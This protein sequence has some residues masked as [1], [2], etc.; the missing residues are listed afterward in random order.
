MSIPND[1]EERPLTF[2]ELRALAEKREKQD[3]PWKKEEE[4]PEV[5][6]EELLALGGKKAGRDIIF[7]TDGET[8]LVFSPSDS[9]LKR[10]ARRTI[11]RWT[12][13]I[14]PIPVSGYD[15]R[16]ELNKSGRE[17]WDKEK[18]EPSLA[19]KAAEQLLACNVEKLEALHVEVTPLRELNESPATEMVMEQLSIVSEQLL[20]AQAAIGLVV[21]VLS[22]KFGGRK[23]QKAFELLQGGQLPQDVT[24]LRFDALALAGELQ[25]PP[26]KRE[27]RERYD[28]GMDPS[29]FAKLLRHAGLSWLPGAKSLAT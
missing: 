3:G 20:S 18:D 6:L 9:R 10:A 23:L 29:Q 26:T 25:R 16:R 15:A 11:S 5:S 27:L 24:K 12:V 22:K 1:R 14:L 21:E 19:F 8:R 13:S 17:L 2:N 7:G 4:L 28:P